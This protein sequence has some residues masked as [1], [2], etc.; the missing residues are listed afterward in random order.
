MENIIKND[1]IENVENVDPK[2]ED[3]N[4]SEMSDN[5]IF[6]LVEE[7]IPESTKRSTSWGIGVFKKWL[8]K[9]QINVNFHEISSVELAIHLK[10]FYAE[11]RKGNGELYTPSALVGIM[12]AIHRY[13]VQPPFMRNINILEGID[14]TSANK[15]FVAKCKIYTAQG[16]PKPQHKPAISEGDMKKLGA[17][18]ADHRNSAQKLLEFVWFTLCY[19][20]GRRGREG[21]RTCTPE[22]FVV[23]RDEEGVTYIT[24]GVTMKT[25][26]H[27]GGNKTD[28]Q[29][30]SE[31]RMYQ[32]DAV[33]S[34]R[35]MVSKRHPSNTALFQTPMKSI[36]PENDVWYK[37]EP[38]GKNKL[39]TLMQKVSKN[40]GLSRVYTAH[41]VRVSMITILF[42]GGVQPDEICAITKHR[43]EAS[44]DSYINGSS[45]AQKRNCSN[46][47]SSALGLPVDTKISFKTTFVYA[48]S[49]KHEK[50]FL[51]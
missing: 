47:L 24:E 23:K 32:N 3:G 16:N 18:F 29:D 1:T 8:E 37:N 40:A 46:V 34:Y 26:N 44:L 10:K 38:M 39:A 11:V 22:S 21:W 12:A 25:K 30:Y 42:Q 5:E 49:L 43:R 4:V 41:S 19:Y 2:V 13:I 45:S 15:V 9:R 7:T 6:A 28:D 35:M 48:C 14:F 27:Q 17:Y 51:R 50:L 36:K 20:F 31:P 33:E